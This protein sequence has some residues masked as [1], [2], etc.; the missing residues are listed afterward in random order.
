LHSPVAA[1]SV[2]DSVLVAFVTQPRGGRV[3][4][5]VEIRTSRE[6]PEPLVMVNWN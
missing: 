6:L 4:A 5:L 3:T 1:V 2:K